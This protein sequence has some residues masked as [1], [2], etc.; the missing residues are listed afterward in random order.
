MGLAKNPVSGIL[1]TAGSALHSLRPL[2]KRLPT[3]ETLAAGDYVIDCYARNASFSQNLGYY[4][5]AT[6]TNSTALSLTPAYGAK[7]TGAD[8]TFSPATTFGFFDLCDSGAGT[9]YTECSRNNLIIDLQQSNGLIFDLT[10]VG[11]KNY[12]YIVAFEDG[13]SCQPKGGD[14]DYNDLVVHMIKTAAVS[15]PGAF[16]LLG[17]GLA[18][19]IA[20]APEKNFTS[21]SGNIPTR[22][23]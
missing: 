14:R 10:N 9:K 7:V 2:S 4:D 13:G 21:S 6:R 5:A 18:R 17:A 20:Y 19:L 15:L 1:S 3:L 23:S 11:G 8:I 16:L 12:G 22:Y